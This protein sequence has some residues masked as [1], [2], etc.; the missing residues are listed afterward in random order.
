MH[1]SERRLIAYLLPLTLV[2]GVLLINLGIY[3]WSL[4]CALPMLIGA[5][6]SWLDSPKCAKDA[7][8]TGA[9]SI[10]IASVVL[11]GA[12]VEGIF[13]VIMALP[14]TLTGG[15]FGAWI[16]YEARR[17]RVQTGSA[18]MLVVLP[19]G[20]FTYDVTAHPPIYAIRSAVEIAASPEQ[21]WKHVITFAGLPEPTEWYFRGGIAYPQRARIEGSGPGAVRYCEFST[22]PFVEPIDVWDEPRLLAFH[23]THNPAPMREWSPNGELDAKHLHGYLVSKQGE[24]RLTQLGPNRTLLEGTTWYQHGLWPAEYWR[25]WS[26]AIIHR[27][28]LRVLN[29]IRALAEADA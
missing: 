8:R 7:M 27:I 29:H 23:V 6:G 28:H 18:A 1:S 3:G 19:F 22:G 25:L 21:V 24:F 11:I 26:D 12:F 10:V 5:I 2:C 14:I 4:F 9:L 20:A 16:V 17:Y 13:C 15:A